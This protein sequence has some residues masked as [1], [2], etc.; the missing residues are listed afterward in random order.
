MVHS[1][2]DK[3]FSSAKWET[4]M[5]YNI[6]WCTAMLYVCNSQATSKCFDNAEDAFATLGFFF[7]S[8]LCILYSAPCKN[9]EVSTKESVHL[10]PEFML[11]SGL[12]RVPGRLI[13]IAYIPECIIHS[14]NF[15][16]PDE[17]MSDRYEHY[18]SFISLLSSL[19][20][21]ILGLV[22]RRKSCFET[23]LNSSDVLTRI[24]TVSYSN[25]RFPYT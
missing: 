13:Q 21:K 8:R 9:K 11:W 12:G 20:F 2:V 14:E 25:K 23:K 5:I 24:G 16:H 22:K 10:K 15:S 19:S 3:V 4:H 18:F 17:P 6:L 1:F 7:D